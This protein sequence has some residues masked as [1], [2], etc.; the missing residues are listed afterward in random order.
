VGKYLGERLEAIKASAPLGGRCALYR[1]VFD[2]RTG[3]KPREQGC[4]ARRG[5][6]QVGKFLR[7]NGLFTFIMAN[8]LGSML[9]VVPPLCITKEQLD[10][11][12]A[13]VEMALEVADKAWS[14][15]SPDVGY[16]K[17]GDFG[18]LEYAKNLELHQRRMD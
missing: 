14:P 16:P 10:E 7:E 5:D 3:A 11:G 17:S 1:P 15:T 4:H 8:N 2:H 9:F 6:G 12:L 13:I 18:F